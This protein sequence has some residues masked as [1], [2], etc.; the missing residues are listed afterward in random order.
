MIVV[1]ITG[2]I[3]TGKSTVCSVWEK[4]GAKIIYAD[5]LAKQLMVADAE[6][7]ERIKKSF[8]DESYQSDG[9]LNKSHL[10]NEAF[11]KE[12]V[13]E[14]NKI[15]H[16]AVR[17]S[18]KKLCRT[19]AEKGT[20][21]LVKEAA[22]LLNYGRPDELDY[23]IIVT[24]PEKHQIERVVKRDGVSD[25]EVLDRKK[26]QPNFDKLLSNADFIINNDGSLEQ[27]KNKAEDVFNKITA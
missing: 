13:E 23:V 1:G 24:A 3:G 20:R 9:S 19:E 12:R 14:L 5:D 25:S 16:P 17:K 7:V 11:K 4:L 22:L 26:K 18:F 15:V 21:I 2:G 8:G 6:V 27:L 10:I